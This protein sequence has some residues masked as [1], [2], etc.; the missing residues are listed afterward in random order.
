MTTYSSEKL[1]N[2]VNMQKPGYTLDQAFYEDPEIFKIDLNTF[3]FNHWIFV[4]HVSRIPNIGD[5][6]L[7]ETGNESIIIIRGK[8]NEIFAHH[9][10]CR[11]RGSRICLEKSGNKKLLVCPYHAW[12]YNIEGSIRSARLMPESF[13]TSKWGLHKCNLRIFEGLIF[14]NFSDNPDDFDE[15]IKPTKPF[16]ELHD[17]SNAK[18]AHRQ[19]YP[20]NGNWKLTLDNF[21][22]CYHCQPAHPEYCSVHDAD[23]ILSFGA[24]SQSGVNSEKF[25]KRLEDWNKKTKNLGHLT[26]VYYEE[27]FSQYSRSAERTP[28]SEGKLT[29]TKDGNPVAPLMGKFKE[30]DGGYTSVGPSPFNSLLMCNDFA[31]LFTFIPK[32]PIETD[33][34]L[35]WLVHKDAVEG[36]D[37]NLENM[38]WMWDQTTI[39]D[40]K[41]IEDNQKGVLSKKYIPGPLSE[42]E[43]SLESFKNWYLKRLLQTI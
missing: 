13:N 4:G 9:N 18:I 30:R 11:H 37:Y 5:Y 33:V 42:M 28:L 16:I 7:F 6:F 39:A 25:N 40:K 12:S 32:G 26:G 14:I 21:H 38:I 29:E 24:G 41:I 1:K 15:F 19:V 23:Y 20:T 36:K 35:M 10:V 17:L 22:E 3:F 8:E 27:R 43:R 34:E 2:L 31:T